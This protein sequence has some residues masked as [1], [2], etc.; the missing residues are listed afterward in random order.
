[1][2]DCELM[3]DM[4]RGLGEDAVHRLA[5]ILQSAPAT[6]ATEGIGLL[7]QISPESVEHVLPVRLAQWPRA[8]HDRTIRPLSSTPAPQR[9]LLLTTIYV[10]LD[11]LIR[12]LALDEMG[13]SGRTE[14]IATLVDLM[15]DDS[16]PGFTRIKAI[17]AAGRLRASGAS[18]IL[19]LFL[20]AKQ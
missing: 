19:Q 8:S 18:P 1:R 15:R 9:A 14:C 13:M 12:P 11:P 5:E 16:T 17:E 20:E 3:G 4:V 2:E 7:S 10:S 6:E